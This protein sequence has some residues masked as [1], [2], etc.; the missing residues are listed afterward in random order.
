MI[1]NILL[2]SSLQYLKN[3]RLLDS[4]NYSVLQR[5]S[6]YATSVTSTATTITIRWVKCQYINVSDELIHST[7]IGAT[8]AKQTYQE[9]PLIE[10]ITVTVTSRIVTNSNQYRSFDF[11]LDCY[12]GLL[13]DTCLTDTVIQTLQCIQSTQAHV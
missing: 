12:L 8:M 3:L 9:Q 7:S 11:K 6:K 13:N 4:C 2:S 1:T 5:H 10:S